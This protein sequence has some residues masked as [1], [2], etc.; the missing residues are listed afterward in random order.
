MTGPYYEVHGLAARAR[1]GLP[2]PP[3][4]PALS[5]LLARSDRKREGR[6]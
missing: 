4:R 2:R 1:M 3:T 6:S 5:L